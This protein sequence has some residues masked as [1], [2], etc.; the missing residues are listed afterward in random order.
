M[1]SA[2]A[3]D[4]RPGS[5]IVAAD[6]G[7]HELSSMRSVPRTTEA[8]PLGTSW[9]DPRMCRGGSPA[10]FE[11][12]SSQSGLLRTTPG[13]EGLAK[14]TADQRLR[15]TIVLGGWAVEACLPDGGPTAE[16]TGCVSVGG[17]DARWL[18]R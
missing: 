8:L 15:N 3:E 13:K 6:P 16:E 17:Q 2:R 14:N 4:S 1:G 5:G 7:S 9:G 18:R 10:P 11:T 12:H